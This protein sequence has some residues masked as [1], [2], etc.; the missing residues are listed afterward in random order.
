MTK[1]SFFNA[2]LLGRNQQSIWDSVSRFLAR[3]LEAQ[4]DRA[5]SVESLR[6]A[7]ID[8]ESPSTSDTQSLRCKG[9]PQL[10]RG[11]GFI[12]KSP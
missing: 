5:S 10:A 3:L 4:K 1:T 6:L 7:G 11:S 9:S 12:A 8:C 2:R